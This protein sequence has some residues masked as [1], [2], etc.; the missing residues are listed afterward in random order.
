MY[1]MASK[2]PDWT[3][4]NNQEAEDNGYIIITKGTAKLAL[5]AL[6][7]VMEIDYYNNYG[8]A[9]EEL[10]DILRRMK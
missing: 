6:E 2:R 7:Q 9:G 10:S 1:P 3:K 4:I 5:S 8:A